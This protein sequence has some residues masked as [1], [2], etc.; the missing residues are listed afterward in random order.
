MD[1]GLQGK[2]AVVSGAGQV[3]GIGWAI[4]QELLREGVRV[5]VGD[6]VL[7]PEYAEMDVLAL[8]LDLG[9]AEAP[10]RLVASAVERFGRLDFLINNLGVTS[11]R[12]GGFLSVTDDDWLATLNLNLLTGVRMVRA[13][14]PHL[15]ERRGAMVFL[16]SLLAREPIPAY[17]DYGASKAAVLN[18][19]KALSLE[20]SPHGV[21]SIAVSPGPVLT[22][23][24]SR[25][26]GQFDQIA[27]AR[28]MDR[29]SVIDT[30]IPD[31]LHLSLG[32][33]VRSEE[34]AAT[35]AFALS[36]RA[37]AMTGCELVIDAGSARAV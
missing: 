29:Q 33:M 4:V 30:V 16:C 18:L 14:L 37:G 28:G 36:D 22:P 6:I 32:R 23:Q 19:A 24:W 5:A 31:M 12:P 1:L 11:P 8:Q 34:V 25:A 7:A 20:F 2:A 10:A 3:G 17:L 21:R 26:G 13:A 9:R 35:I 15:L 27:A